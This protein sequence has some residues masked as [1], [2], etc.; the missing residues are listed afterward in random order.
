MIFLFKPFLPGTESPGRLHCEIFRD[1]IL[2]FLFCEFE[3]FSFLARRVFFLH[4]SKPILG[5][6]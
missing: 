6:P 4:P 2:V 1:E 5:H 3:L